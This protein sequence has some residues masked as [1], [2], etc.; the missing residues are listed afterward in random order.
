MQYYYMSKRILSISSIINR[1][2][3]VIFNRYVPGSG[4]GA[5]SISVRRAKMIKATRTSA[6][7]AISPPVGPASSMTFNGLS[8][9][10]YDNNNAFDIGTNDFTIEWFQYF[11]GVQSF[12]R[13]FSIGSYSSELISIAVSYEGV[14]YF[15]HNGNPRVIYNENPPT[16][17]WSHIAIVGSGGNQVKIY[18]NGELKETLSFSYNF[19]TTGNVPLTIGNETDPSISANFSG[20]ITNFRWVIGT[21]VYTSNFTPPNT[22]LTNITGTQLLLLATDGTNIAKDYSDNNRTP[23]NV[24]VVSSTNTPF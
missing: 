12:P 22:P 19:N 13:P 21:Q 4:V 17:V 16:N 9:I 1:K 11:T 23:T 18:L 3:T 15:W 7:P 5:T 24:N 6:K 20:Q 10:Q 14:T 8:Y 2:N